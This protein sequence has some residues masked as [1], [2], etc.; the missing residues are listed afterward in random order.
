MKFLFQQKKKKLLIKLLLFNVFI[1]ALESHESISFDNPVLH[2]FLT[3]RVTIFD[4]LSEVTFTILAIYL[5]LAKQLPVSSLKYKIID[6]IIFSLSDKSLFNKNSA[7]IH[8]PF[9][10]CLLI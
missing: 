4:T 7:G 10:F 5:L 9:N 2:P 1:S 3:G 6:N 8:N